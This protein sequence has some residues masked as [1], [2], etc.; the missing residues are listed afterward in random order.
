MYSHGWQSPVGHMWALEL[1]SVTGLERTVKEHL[2]TC[3]ITE[4]AVGLEGQNALRSALCSVLTGCVILRKPLTL[5]MPQLP[6][7]QH[8]NSSQCT[9]YL[10]ELV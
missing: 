3:D 8:G 1:T 7:L 5:S 9:I 10:K 2:Y 4:R 6:Q